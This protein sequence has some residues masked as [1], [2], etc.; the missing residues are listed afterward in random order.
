MRRRRRPKVPSFAG[1]PVP[2]H[3]KGE[4]ERSATLVMTYFHPWTLQ[5]QHGDDFVPWAG[6]LRRQ[7]ESWQDSLKGW[8]DGNVLCLEAAYL[9][10]NFLCVYRVR[11]MDDDDDSLANSDDIMGSDEDFV[12]SNDGLETAL[13]TRLGGREDNAK[14][15]EN[16]S[17]RE[18][19]KSAM[20]LG[21]DIWGVPDK[22]DTCET[23]PLREETDPPQISLRS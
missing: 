5:Q 2:K 11:P 23:Q 17:H 21:E 12:L 10:N 8:L 3:C 13:K 1:A 19:S 22:T 15:G 14:T 4:E 6:S 20:E 16:S 9:V 7:D 18:N